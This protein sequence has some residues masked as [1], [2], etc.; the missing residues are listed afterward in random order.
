MEAAK[1]VDGVAG[2]VV[3]AHRAD[4]PPASTFARFIRAE[5]RVE[6]ELEEPLVLPLL[7]LPPTRASTAARRSRT[8]SRARRRRQLLLCG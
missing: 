7:P 6:E 8:V 5:G 2:G 1:A 3:A 4:V